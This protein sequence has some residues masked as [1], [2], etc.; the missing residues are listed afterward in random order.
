MKLTRN[1]EINDRIVVRK[2]IRSDYES[3]KHVQDIDKIKSL[4]QV[5][6]QQL[7]I[8]EKSQTLSK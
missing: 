7:R 3:Y 8:M 2:W 6:Y 1:L 4:L 5:A